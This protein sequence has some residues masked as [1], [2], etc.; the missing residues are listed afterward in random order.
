M[1]FIGICLLGLFVSGYALDQHPLLFPL[2]GDWLDEQYD[3]ALDGIL[4]N[5]SPQDTLKGTVVASPSKQHPNYWY[6]WTRDAAITM[7]VIVQLYNDTAAQ[8]GKAEWEQL[9]IDYVEHEWIV[10]QTN[11]PSG[12]SDGGGLGEPKFQVD[13][14]PFTGPWGRP[15]N[16]GPA[17]RALT[18]TH[19]AKAY[20]THNAHSSA[21]Y[22][23]VERYLYDGRLPTNSVIKADLEYVA[24]NIFEP[25]YDPWEEVQAENNFFVTLVSAAALMEGANLAESLGDEGAASWYRL[26]AE[27][28][29]DQVRSLWDGERMVWNATK[30]QTGGIGWKVSNLDTAVL[31]TSL[32]TDLPEFSPYTPGI[33]STAHAL[34]T[35][36]SSEYAINAGERYPLLGRYGEDRYDGYDLS[37]GNPWFLCTM[38]W[39]EV[40]YATVYY[41]LQ[42]DSRIDT[43]AATG[44]WGAYLPLN[45][46]TSLLDPHSGAWNETLCGLLRDGDERLEHIKKHRGQ[47]KEEFGFM[48]EQLDRETGYMVGAKELTWSYVQFVRTKWARDRVMEEAGHRGLACD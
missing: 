10:Q 39:S 43:E 16:D 8:A 22:D 32:Y 18:L 36:F 33:L 1:N 41:Y 44:F 28:Y 27:K 38:A 24:G 26:G 48:S 47:D 17:L 7:E 20:L 9:L 40:M 46:S 19:F 12:S 5:I 14:T 29:E 11:N 2:S 31:L 6:H 3:I 45:D 13:G 34:N 4:S 23:Y 25:S 42:K 37:E 30:G 21:A 35:T 15:Q